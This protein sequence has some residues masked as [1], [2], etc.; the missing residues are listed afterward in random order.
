MSFNIIKGEELSVNSLIILL[1]GD[2]STGKT[3]TALTAER[4]FI[5]DFDGGVHRSAMKTGKPIV[6]IN[7]W[8]EMVSEFPKFEQ[9]LK[10]YQTIVIDT[11]DTCLDYIRIYVENQDFKLKKNKLHMYGALKDEFFSFT[12]RLTKLG[13]DI[14]FIAHATQDEKNGIM[15]TVPKITGG[16]KDLVRQ[17]ADFVG[18]MFTQNNEKTLN[19][20]ST[21]Y[22]EGKNS[23]NIPILKL[24]N[25]A[26]TPDYFSEIINQMKTAINGKVKAQSE[27]VS[28]LKTLFSDL[29]SVTNVKELNEFY[30]KL[31][32]EKLIKI[33]SDQIQAKLKETFKSLDCTF[34]KE[35]MIFV[36]NK[37]E[38]SETKVNDNG[39]LVSEETPQ[40]FEI[41]FD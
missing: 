18:Y 6:R 8:E 20:S 41:T 14:I 1:Y 2:I 32:K 21:D 23:A 10:D 38:P 33:E 30:V 4:P 17:K 22:Y 29:A 16:S 3:S 36:T 40:P 7:K 27:S 12:N 25:Y 11:V 37:K 9:S 13:K 31:T 26:Q 39:E 24:P 5:F 15:V 19:F 35:K 34:D 28:K